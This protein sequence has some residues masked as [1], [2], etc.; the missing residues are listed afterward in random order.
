MKIAILGMGEGWD[1]GNAKDYDEMWAVSPLVLRRGDITKVFQIHNLDWSAA[2]NAYLE[3]KGDRENF[4]DSMEIINSQKIPIVLQAEHEFFP[5]GEI[6]PLDEMPALY[7][8]S[9]FAYM[10][11][12]ALYKRA[13][14]IDLYGVPL[15][16]E[17]EYREQRSCLEFWIG[18]AAGRGVEVNIYGATIL[19]SSIPYEG[20]YGYDW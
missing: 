1:R 14:Q 20:L 4:W 9:T 12:Y 3:L 15:V 10:M 8:T 11:A 7:F 18:F 16:L 19:L 6:F 5:H 2:D 13:T 17:G